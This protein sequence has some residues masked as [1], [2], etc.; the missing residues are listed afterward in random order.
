MVG[1][2]FWN[3]QHIRN[4]PDLADWASADRERFVAK[5]FF[6]WISVS[7]LGISSPAGWRRCSATGV[8]LR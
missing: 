4:L 7:M 8:P 5:V 1:I 2:A 6:I 3:H